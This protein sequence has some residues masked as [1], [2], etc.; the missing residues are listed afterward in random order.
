MFLVLII[1]AIA[2]DISWTDATFLVKNPFELPGEEWKVDDSI[3]F[4]DIWAEMEK[5]YESGRAK[6]IG[7]SNFSIKK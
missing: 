6:A 2:L 3:T 4:Q 5:I 1:F 7:V